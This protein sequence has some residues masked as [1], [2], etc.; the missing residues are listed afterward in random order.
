MKK[1]LYLIGAVIA[2]IVLF[3]SCSAHRQMNVTG[4]TQIITVDTTYIDHGG[5]LTIKTKN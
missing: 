1:L 2:V 3:C 4:R 5:S